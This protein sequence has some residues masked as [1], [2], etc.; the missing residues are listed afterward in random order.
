MGLRLSVAFAVLSLSLI[1]SPD[2]EES[3]SSDEELA[4][5]LT[6]LGSSSFDKPTRLSAEIKYILLGFVSFFLLGFGVSGSVS[7]QI[8]K[9]PPVTG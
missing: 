2:E 1:S 8:T 6:E 7:S 4:T 9:T 3:W 5:E